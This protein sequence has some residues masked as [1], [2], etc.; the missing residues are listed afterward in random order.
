M[1]VS[2]R[3]KRSAVELVAVAALLLDLFYWQ[4][5]VVFWIS[6]IYLLM[7][8]LHYRR[9]AALNFRHSQAIRRT[10][11]LGAIKAIERK[12]TMR[13]DFN[14]PDKRALLRGPL[15]RYFYYARYEHARQLL[16]EY[17]SSA[18]RILDMGCGFGKNALYI[19]QEL[20]CTAIGLELDDLKLQWARR[21]LLGA[22]G[23]ENIAFVC[24][25]A[26]QPPFQSASF[27][28]ILLA[29]VLE[30][31]LDPP[32]GL[33]ACNDLLR[34]E[35]VLL[36]TTPSRHN[37]NYSNNPL[38]VLEKVLSL[39][40]ERVLPPYHNLHAQFEFNWR[41][42]E[43]EY[44]IHYHFSRQKLESLL[45]G[46]GFRLVWRGSFE[47]EI[48]P[49]LLIE[50]CT[51]GD[52]GSMSRYLDTLESTIARVPVLKHLGQHLM[53]VAQKR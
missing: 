42:P 13:D 16:A 49:Y 23:P 30:H 18:R 29:E 10:M 14:T 19:C 24:A 1:K 47:T 52:A 15:D 38:F 7:N 27:D 43:P 5:R 6:F 22:A 34:K 25:D 44:G 21:H 35:G 51:R 45:E 31:L 20:H 50:L 9:E 39:A 41:K 40:C 17:A 11:N 32:R 48:F 3:F 4:H 46:A 12:Y 37:L 28:C 2:K 36:V 26:A 53:Y 33:S 8:Y